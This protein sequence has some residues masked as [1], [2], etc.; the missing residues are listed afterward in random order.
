MRY[1]PGTE[2][3][4]NETKRANT[5]PYTYYVS[6]HTTKTESGNSRCFWPWY[7]L[8][9]SSEFCSHNPLR[10]ISPGVYCCACHVRSAEFL[11]A[12]LEEQRTCVAFCSKLRETVLETP[13]FTVTTLKRHSS[14]LSA[15]APPLHVRRRQ[16]RCKNVRNLS[17]QT[18]NRHY[19]NQ[20]SQRLRE[21]LR[22]KRPEQGGTKAGWITMTMRQHTLFFLGN[23]YWII[24]HGCRPHSLYMPYLTPAISSCFGD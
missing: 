4:R 12:D 5:Y 3:Q 14:S 2:K 21:Q 22:R 16:V 24:K 7:L 13:G 1:Y 6:E 15:K 9:R 11:M 20:V 19:Y 23:N 10:C 18:V 8:S 17:L